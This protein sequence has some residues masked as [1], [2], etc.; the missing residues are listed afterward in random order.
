VLLREAER[1]RTVALGRIDDVETRKLHRLDGAGSTASWVAQQQTSLDRTEVAL[2]RRL[3]S[4]PLI[5]QALRTGGLATSVA[6]RLAAALVKL[7]RHLNRPDGLIDGQDGEL[8]LAATI[9]D[10]VSMLVRESAGG[11]D[12][13]SPRSSSSA[14][15][16]SWDPTAGSPTTTPQ[17]DDG[18]SERPG[19]RTTVEYWL[20][21][22]GRFPS[23][24]W[25]SDDDIPARGRTSIPSTLGPAEQGQGWSRL[26]ESNR[27]QPHYEGGRG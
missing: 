3:S 24:L 15:A 1:L 13:G 9:I 19:G 7:R 6:A 27:G 5:S 22:N 25:R 12:E 4:F 11:L 14:P 17:H 2:A 18:D 21:C 16:D 20:S 23:T 8:V 10:G 26:A